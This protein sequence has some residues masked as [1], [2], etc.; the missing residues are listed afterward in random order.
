MIHDA[1]KRAR[2][3]L[4]PE[5]SLIPHMAQARR[6]AAS[7]ISINAVRLLVSA[8]T[9]TSVIVSEIAVRTVQDGSSITTGGTATASSQ[10]SGTYVP[11]RA[12]DGDPVTQWWSAASGASGQWIQYTFAAPVDFST[13]VECAFMTANASNPPTS[14]AWQYTTDGGSTWTTFRTDSIA[15]SSP[16]TAT[17]TYL[18]W[19]VTT[20]DDTCQIDHTRITTSVGNVLLFGGNNRA[21]AAAGNWCPLANKTKTSGI[22][23]FEMTINSL[24]FAGLSLGFSSQSMSLTSN[25][26]G[27][28]GGSGMVMTQSGGSVTSSQTYRDAAAI[29]TMGTPPATISAG[30]TITIV[31]DVDN[32]KAWWWIGTLY[33]GEWNQGLPS[34]IYPAMAFVNGGDLTFNFGRKPLFLPLQKG[35]LPYD[36]DPS[37]TYS[38]DT[39]GYEIWR[40]LCQTP[41][42]SINIAEWR[43]KNSSGTNFLTGGDCTAPGWSVSNTPANA[44]DGNTA[45]AFQCANSR[46]DLFLDYRTAAGV[47]NTPASL[48][49]VSSSATFRPTSVTLQKSTD[50]GRTFSTVKIAS[51]LSYTGSP[52]TAT[53]AI[54]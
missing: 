45:T 30:T 36:A 16:K 7:G 20:K 18:Y 13:V 11:S 52:A 8:G 1:W 28:A 37:A 42:T 35:A 3:L 50:G 41:T 10:N 24:G 29:W 27:N 14:W 15:S 39:N 53:V 40:L 34:N 48:E 21:Y 31:W 44:V 33:M 43:L 2:P 51:G 9:S 47:T 4:V 32:A 54:P 22:W 46:G 38:S 23:Q 17:A 25:S 26:L 6:A 49:I 19:V 5:L 12:F